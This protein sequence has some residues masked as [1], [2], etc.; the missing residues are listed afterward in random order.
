MQICNL[1]DHGLSFLSYPLHRRSFTIQSPRKNF[2]DFPFSHDRSMSKSPSSSISM[3][4][5]SNGVSKSSSAV[6]I[7][8]TPAERTRQAIS[9]IKGAIEKPR[10][11]SFP[12]IECEFPALSALNKLGDGSLRSA[13]EAENAN[14]EFT[15]QLIQS[16]K[17]PLPLGPKK[18]IWLLTSSAASNSLYNLVQRKVSS[19]AKVHSLKN[20]LP[21][22]SNRDIAIL[23]TPSAKGDYVAAEKLASNGITSGVIII[24]GF[25][26]VRG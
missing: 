8:K 5:G 23:I 7:P 10:T 9:C 21:S 19:P 11:P 17:S 22:V 15:M 1:F 16:L 26:K 2:C 14:A 4:F 3:I 6:Q 20:G 12:L 24:N 18:V 25:A 13:Q